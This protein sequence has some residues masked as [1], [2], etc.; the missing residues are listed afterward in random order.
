MICVSATY[1]LFL[2]ELEVNYGDTG[3]KRRNKQP[4]T[5]VKKQRSVAFNY[6]KVE[7]FILMRSDHLWKDVHNERMVILSDNILFLL[8]SV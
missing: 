4:R 2:K 5:T 3:R 1:F 7:E 8:T 6:C